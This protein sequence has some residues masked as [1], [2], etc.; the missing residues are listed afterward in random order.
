MGTINSE[1]ES[2]EKRTLSG[3]GLLKV[4]QINYGKTRFLL[5][6]ADVI[7]FASTRYVNLKYNP[8]KGLYAQLSFMLNGYVVRS[9][10]MVYD[11][12]LWRFELDS[13]SQILQALTCS[14]QGILDSFANI[15]TGL[16]LIVVQK[17]NN[18]KDFRTVPFYFDEI[19]VVC[20]ADTAIQLELWK[21]NDFI[22]DDEN[23][24]GDF[25]TPPDRPPPPS[26]KP[27]GTPLNNPGDLSPSYDGNN[28][29]G[30]SEP[31]EGDESKPPTQGVQCEK[32]R[33]RYSYVYSVLGNPR[34]YG[35]VVVW[36]EIGEISATYQTGVPGVG[37]LA[38]LYL[39]CRGYGNAPCGAFR[40]YAIN[41][42]SGAARPFLDPAIES[43]RIEV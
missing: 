32:Y 37:A 41:Q 24:Q 6:Y 33:V 16:Q 43:V 17:Q 34:T 13:S 36:G 25:P 21:K 31:F 7:R 2:I 12:Q 42:E 30:D 27:P 11:R 9:E 18:L 8:P 15:A 1:W 3:K 40:S 14:Y 22:C 26:R 20:E 35:D 10:S 19:K 5:L 39:E 28:D 4:P 38:L 29:N 23:N